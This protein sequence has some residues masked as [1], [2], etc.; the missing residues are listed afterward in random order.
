MIENK[1]PFDNYPFEVVNFFHGTNESFSD[2]KNQND[3]PKLIPSSEKYFP[4]DLNENNLGNNN[5]LTNLS[6]YIFNDGRNNDDIFNLENN[7]LQGNNKRAKNSITEI[8]S[9]NRNIDNIQN[10]STTCQ[11][12]GKELIIGNQMTNGTFYDLYKNI[13]IKEETLKNLQMIKKKRRR[14]TKKEIE[15]EKKSKVPEIKKEKKRGRKKQGETEDEKN[16]KKHGKNGEDNISKKI[17]TV[18]FESAINCM[19]KSFIK[20]NLDFEDI[21]LN[22]KYHRNYFLKL[23]PVLIINRIKKQ[24]RIEILNSSFKEIFTKYPISKRYKKYSK[25][26][27]ID[28]I[29]KIYKEN[30]QPFV[31]YMLDMTFSDYL[32]FFTGKTST[33]D[34][35]NYF[36]ENYNFDETVILKFIN[37]FQNIDQFLKKQHEYYK[38]KG[39]SDEEIKEY[40]EIVNLLC[41]NYKKS[42]E[43]KFER[44]NKKNE[45]N[46]QKDN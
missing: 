34:I 5:S 4:D 13:E 3:E 22:K 41:L 9:D 27:N 32:N 18:I 14:R 37:N 43:D 31:K 26:S 23:E 39:N 16:E 38:K 11:I 40:L 6:P 1:F 28:L 8:L 12:N 24:I 19:N 20:E 45:K 30:N 44:N 25:S 15:L 46:T 17:N 7:I 29:D 33:K 21:R 10:K 42:F 35:I 2:G 36:K